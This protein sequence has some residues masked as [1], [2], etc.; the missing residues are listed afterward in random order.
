MG[1][2]RGEG[3]VRSRYRITGEMG[4]VT[5]MFRDPIPTF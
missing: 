1:G 4:R 2:R 3:N 5:P